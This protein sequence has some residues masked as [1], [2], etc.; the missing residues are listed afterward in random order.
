[1]VTTVVTIC[2]GFLKSTRVGQNFCFY[3][4]HLVKRINQKHHLLC[5]STLYLLA[6]FYMHMPHLTLSPLGFLLNST[7]SPTMSLSLHT[8]WTIAPLISLAT[9]R[10][11]LWKQDTVTKR[12]FSFFLQKGW[13]DWNWTPSVFSYT[14]F[15]KAQKSQWICDLCGHS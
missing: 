14:I 5:R 12:K 13:S 11:A 6:Y 8:F 10:G 3:H 7:A 15:P 4:Q 9:P 1:M 2:V